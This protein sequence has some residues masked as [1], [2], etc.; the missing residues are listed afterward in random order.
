MNGSRFF[1]TFNLIHS[2][3]IHSNTSFSNTQKFQYLRV[4][5]TGDANTVIS[6]LEL[7]DTDYDIAWSI[8]RDQCDN[9]RVIVQT[10]VKAIMDLQGKGKFNRSQKN[11]WRVAKHLH[12]LQTLKRPTTH[13]DD[14]LVLILNLTHSHYASGTFFTDNELPSLKRNNCEIL[15]LIDIKCSRLPQE[16]TFPQRRS[17]QNRSQM[18]SGHRCARLP[19]NLNVTFIT[20][21]I[22]AK[23]S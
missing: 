13:W 20:S 3:V 17:R 5:L 2:L 6:S 23:T 15:S 12:A 4:S 14:L 22:I 7:S 18:L 16:L 8:L 11:L 1:D 10:H 9:K 21:F 19:L